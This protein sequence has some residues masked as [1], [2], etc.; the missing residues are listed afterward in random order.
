MSNWIW[1]EAHIER[2]KRMK[3]DD[4][5]SYRGKDR[6]QTLFLFSFFKLYLFI[7]RVLSRKKRANNPFKWF[8]MMSIFWGSVHIFVLSNFVTTAPRRRES[9]VKCR[10][11]GFIQTVLLPSHLRWMFHLFRRCCLFVCCTIVVAI[12]FFLLTGPCPPSGRPAAA[13]NMSI[14]FDSPSPIW[15]TKSA[16]PTTTYTVG[17]TNIF[18][19][20]DHDV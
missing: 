6:W 1:Y 7:Y 3:V 9:I 10:L 12:I 15:N 20:D 16:C 11:V 13:G 5:S 19:N 17:W 8:D 4:S 2:D 14:D 18:D